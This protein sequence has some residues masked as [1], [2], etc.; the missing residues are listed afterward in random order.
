MI[1]KKYYCYKIPT[2]SAL[3]AMG[4]GMPLQRAYCHVRACDKQSRRGS[5]LT[6]GAN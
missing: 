2:G 6:E 4:L 3:T 5:M 1:S